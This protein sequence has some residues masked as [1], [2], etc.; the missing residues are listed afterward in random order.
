MNSVN[1]KNDPAHL[2]SKLNAPL[3][4]QFH[5]LSMGHRG[6]ISGTLAAQLGSFQKFVGTWG[7]PTSFGRA[8]GLGGANILLFYKAVQRLGWKSGWLSVAPENESWPHVSLLY[9]SKSW[10]RVFPFD[11]MMIPS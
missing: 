8:D 6:L 7:L 4:C 9:Q 1:K 11:N 10:R 5:C 2:L 3:T